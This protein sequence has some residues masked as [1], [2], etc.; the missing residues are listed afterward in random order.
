MTRSGMSMAIAVALSRRTLVRARRAMAR[1]AMSLG[2]GAALAWSMPA[3]G[4][5]ADPP[6]PKVGDRWT[7][8]VYYTVPT[9]VPGRTW[10]VTEVS[11]TGITVSED[12]EPV[13]LTRELNV[14][15]S[16]R[17][18]ESNPRLLAFPMKVGNR[19]TY[20]SDWDFKPKAAHGRAVVEVVVAAHEKVRVPAGEFD[21]FRLTS[22]ETLSGTSPI[23]S[24]YAGQVTRTYWYAP[25][26][27]AIVKSVTRHP[28]LGP[29][30]VELVDIAL[31]P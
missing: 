23:G 21:A 7:F 22:T 14:L 9:S 10:L 26:A 8:A 1:R 13:R 3:A 29:S 12:G 2:L 24:Q 30:T 17:A 27:R 18:R 16:P 6:S 25:T 11:S 4:Q 31:Q 15:E 28:Y 19:W 20:T 5:V